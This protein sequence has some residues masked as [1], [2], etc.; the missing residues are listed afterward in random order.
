MA[1]DFDI[2]GAL[3]L[4]KKL[5]MLSAQASGRAIRTS[6]SYALTPVVKSARSRAPKGSVAHK[7]YQ[8]RTVAPGFMSRSIKKRSKI[9][10]DK[11]AAYAWVALAPE[12]FYGIFVEKGLDNKD[13]QARPWLGPAFRGNRALMLRRYSEKLKE[14]IRIEAAK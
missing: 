2:Q 8:G 4:S 3:G 13:Y 1:D 10:K 9:S 11:S 6:V 7:T 14:R 5:K 12:A